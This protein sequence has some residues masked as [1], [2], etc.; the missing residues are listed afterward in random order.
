MMLSTYKSSLKH[1]AF[2]QHAAKMMIG[3][4]MKV[5]GSGREKNSENA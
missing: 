5:L 3:D 4:G 2:L 1:S